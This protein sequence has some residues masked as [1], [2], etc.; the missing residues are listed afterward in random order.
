V[1]DPEKKYFQYFIYA[2]YLGELTGHDSCPVNLPMYLG[3][4]LVMAAEMAVG[5]RG[6]LS[7]VVGPD[8]EDP[9]SVICYFTGRKKRKT[10]SVPLVELLES[11]HGKR[12]HSDY[13]GIGAGEHEMSFAR[14]HERTRVKGR[15]KEVFCHVF[16]QYPTLGS[17]KHLATERAGRSDNSCACQIG[18]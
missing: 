5:D 18:G 9:E 8:P 16:K 14:V 6:R 11:K 10:Q 12:L 15:K 1:A 4:D 7:Q 17:H 3:I 13:L 2:K